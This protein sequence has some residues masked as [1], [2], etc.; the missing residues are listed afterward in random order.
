M[1]GEPT[2]RALTAGEADVIAG[3]RYPPPYDVYDDR[4]DDGA[5]PDALEVR[6]AI[7]EDGELVG[8]CSFGADGRVPGGRYPDGPLDVGIG[9]RPDLTGRGLGARYLAAVVG[10]ARRELGATGLRVTVAELNARAL[11]LFEVAGFRR[12]ERFE[13]R[14]RPFWILERVN[15]E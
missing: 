12:V 10:F 6:Y 7:I 8:F 15:E 1:A 5:G 4:G 11:R 2:V 3:W 9:M 13:G 14:D